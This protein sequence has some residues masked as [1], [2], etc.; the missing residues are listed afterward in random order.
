MAEWWHQN[1]SVIPRTHAWSKPED[2]RKEVEDLT[3]CI[4]LLLD[5]SVINGNIDLANEDLRKI[6]DQVQQ[7]MRNLKEDPAVTESAWLR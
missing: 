3:G 7:F 1:E 5:K 2:Y 6:H 4:P